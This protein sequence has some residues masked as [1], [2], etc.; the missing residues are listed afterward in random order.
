[1]VVNPGPFHW[2]EEQLL[3]EEGHQRPNLLV[4]LGAMALPEAEQVE[5]QGL[6]EVLDLLA[7]ALRLVVVHLLL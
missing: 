2:V 6:R 7:T 3:L 1:M 5:V 4:L